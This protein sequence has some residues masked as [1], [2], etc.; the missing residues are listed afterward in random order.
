MS[1]ITDAHPG[2]LNTNASM[3]SARKPTAK[4]AIGDI[5]I[6]TGLGGADGDCELTP[7]SS[8]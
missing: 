2:Q 3:P 8:H 6:T 1:R 4:W 7:P 5:R